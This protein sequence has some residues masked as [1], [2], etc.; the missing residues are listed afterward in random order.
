MIYVQSGSVDYHLFICSLLLDQFNNLT[1]QLLTL[2]SHQCITTSD[3]FRKRVV[4]NSMFHM[5]SLAQKSEARFWFNSLPE[6]FH[7]PIINCV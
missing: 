1:S 4:W 3:V 5:K 6:M 2:V 7:T